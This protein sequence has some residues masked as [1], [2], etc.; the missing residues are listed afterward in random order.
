MEEATNLE[1]TRENTKENSLKN[2]K[3]TVSEILPAECELVNVELE[4]PDV[5]I[6]LHN[7]GAF[8]NDES[9]IKKLAGTL[10]KKI[11]VRCDPKLMV[12]PET[13]LNKIKEIVP[14]EA[15]I[16]SINF[17]PQFSEAVIEAMKPGLV[18]G[19]QGITLRQIME[20][21]GWAVRILRQ[22]TMPSE[23][24]DGIRAS[25]LK[26]SQERKK[27]LIKLGKKLST[28]L[29]GKSEWVK[30]TAL[31]GFKE[32]G[33][34]C[35]L[36]ETQNNKVLI[37]CGIN[38]ETIE[39]KRAYPYLNTIDFSLDELDAVICT[40]AHMD[41]CGFIPYLYAYGYDGP[42]YCTKPTRDLMALLQ[43]DYLNIMKRSGENAPYNE[44]DVRKAFNMAITRDFGEVTDITPEM[45]LTFQ[46]AGH[47]LGSAMVHLH[48]GDGLHNL[49]HTG[50][51][52]F[53]PSRLLNPAHYTFPRI[54]TLLTEA[55]YGS[56]SAVLPKR[57]DSEINLMN[58]IKKTLENKGKVL[59]PVFSVGRSQEMMLL[60]EEYASKGEFNTPVYLDGMIL[61]A[62]A[63]H[64]AYP[65]YLNYRI[66]Q[67]ILSND[68]P[69]ESE[70]F[71]PVK[72][73]RKEIVEGDPCVILAPS[74][75]LSGGPSVEYL[76]MMAENPANLL[77]FVGYQSATSI[78]RKIQNGLKDIPIVGENGKMST[79][80]MNMQVET[81]DGFSGH[82][83]W[84]QLLAFIKNLEPKPKEVLTMHG[85]E[86]RCNELAD[87]ISHFYRINT[88]IPMNMDT[89]R[90]K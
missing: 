58:T 80:K 33:R 73:N 82:S 78:G 66:H 56:R 41:H 83:D 29:P 19:K 10:R 39:P 69:F 44:K 47:I 81:I 9:I 7:V 49:V 12:D 65:E 24:I 1:A 8:F 54:E 34:S 55:T 14:A 28:E 67:R 15:A 21:T 2:L 90:L 50:D 70:I 61:E 42:L 26:E 86:N 51:Y 13:A 57:V 38:A 87:A 59:I 30:I 60:L 23:T 64:T 16:K 85:D 40:H 75:M 76:H 35:L 84:R 31:G 11:L 20:Q 53:G 22:P 52:K 17:D 72:K 77:V 46:N 6:Y 68:S 62:S 74:G 63:I 43:F 71:E 32:V 79:V 37:D 88:R 89:L 36:L 45:R 27:M 48:I 4:G 3:K 25:I 18:I 5:V